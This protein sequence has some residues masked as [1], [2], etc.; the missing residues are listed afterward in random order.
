MTALRY[1]VGPPLVGPEP[2]R[3]PFDAAWS[4]TLD[5]LDREAHQLSA[6]EIVIEGSWRRTMVR[7]NGQL[8][9]DVS[10]PVHP[11]V[12]V[13]LLGTTHGD[14]AYPC[15]RFRAW[16]DNVRAVALALESLRRVDRYG[17]AGGGRQYTGFAALPA[18]T[19]GAALRGRAL[20][21]KYGGER[22]A[23]HATHPDHGGAPEDFA[24]VQAARTEGGSK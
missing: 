3:S 2:V 10:D 14:L 7:R 9:A 16:R 22:A 8:R 4:T 24:A 1:E 17:I 13:H 21:K 20:I 23:L 18:G 6:R 5:D 11:G 12:T 15:V 19:G